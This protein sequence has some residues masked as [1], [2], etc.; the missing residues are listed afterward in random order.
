MDGYNIDCK[1]YWDEVKGGDDYVYL[2]VRS[3]LLQYFNRK[4]I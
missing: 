3:N 4:N 2:F 1:W